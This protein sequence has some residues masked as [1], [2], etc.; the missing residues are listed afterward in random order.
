MGVQLFARI[1]GAISLLAGVAGFI[2]VLA[3]IAPPDAEVVTLDAGYSYLFGRFP[4]N[5]MH[6]GV[7]IAAGVFALLASARFTWARSAMR[8]LFWGFLLL[9]LLG[10]IPIT[11]TLFGIMPLYGYD[12]PLHLG[13]ALIAGFAGYARPSRAPAPPEAPAKMPPPAAAGTPP[14]R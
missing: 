14:A 4:V 9:A 10:A 11:D 3:P 2:P 13:L 7:H 8:L 5:V 6:D 1:M 12:V